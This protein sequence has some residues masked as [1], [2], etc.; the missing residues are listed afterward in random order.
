[1]KRGL[2]V[3]CVFFVVLYAAPSVMAAGS[4]QDFLKEVQRQAGTERQINA[5]REREFGAD[6]EAARDQVREAQ[7][8]LRQEQQ[9]QS[10]LAA[11][12]DAN[13]ADLT[14]LE[15]ELREQQGGLGEVFGVVRQS[16]GDFHAQL[17]GSLAMADRPEALE[18]LAEL[19]GARTL[20][21][22]EEL[23]RLWLV[24]LEDMVNAGEVAKFSGEVVSPDGHK[25]TKS[26]VRVGAFN[27][28]A[29][30]SYLAH[31]E[32]RNQFLE[33]PR[34]PAGRYLGFA[35]DLQDAPAGEVRPF[36]L[37]PSRGAILSQLVQSPSLL[38]RVRQGREIGMIILALGVFGIG[39]FAAR[40]TYL[41]LV[42]HRVKAQLRSGE[43][44]QDN[45]LG[46]I[47]ALYDED[48][49]LA[50]E[51]LEVKL[52]EA[53]MREIPRLEWGLTTIKIL[54]AVAP[55][56]GLLGTVVGMIETFQSITLFGTGD[57]QLMAGGISQALVTTALGLTVAIPLLFLHNVASA[58]SR[59][60]VNVMEEQGAGLLARHMEKMRAD[61]EHV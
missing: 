13:E 45:P 26:I 27:A 28:V 52:D 17:M 44:A 40:Y 43:P 20:P 34:Q 53:V 29:D 47:L 22:I 54:A 7:Q 2:T 18:F 33:L 25:Q 58:K 23:E 9:R 1:M 15:A 3:F 38:E 30:G 46:R 59:Y 16:A 31:V 51:T 61:P 10:N 49:Q 14:K 48:H 32:G 56:L 41:H 36:A 37:D 8:R 55:L 11:S 19:S 5:E 21:G 12:F 39:L 57:P 6:L 50:P 60:L 42:N 35:R 4:L 24:V